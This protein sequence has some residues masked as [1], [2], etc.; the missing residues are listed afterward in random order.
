MTQE[1]YK[2][3][4]DELTEELW[5]CIPP[6]SSTSVNEF[7]SFLSSNATQLLID[8]E[9]RKKMIQCLQNLVTR[10]V[11]SKVL[12]WFYTE[13]FRKVCVLKHFIFA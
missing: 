8:V 2:E 7:H 10:D 6:P 11:D 4:L 13:I 1:N 5:G 3:F 12:D 9:K